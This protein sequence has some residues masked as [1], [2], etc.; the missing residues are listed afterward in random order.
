MCKPWPGVA[1]GQATANK[2]TTSTTDPTCNASVFSYSFTTSTGIT[3]STIG[4]TR[5]ASTNSSYDAN[6]TGLI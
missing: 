4:T 6:S 2:L 5:I 1:L 3:R